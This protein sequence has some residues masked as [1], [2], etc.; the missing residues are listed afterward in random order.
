MKILIKDIQILDPYQPRNSSYKAD[1]LIEDGIIQEIASSFSPHL[2]GDVVILG[3]NKFLFPGLIDLHTHLREPGFEYKEDIASGSLAALHG[4]YT[5]ITAFPNTKP[6]SDSVERLLALKK[7]IQEKALVSVL[8]VAAITEGLEG[9]KLTPIAD[10]AKNGAVAFT[11]DGKG[12]Q[13]FS[14]ALKAMQAIQ[15]TGLPFLIHAENELLAQDGVMHSGKV[16]EKLNLKGIPPEAEESMTARDLILAKLT[17]AQIHFCHVSTAYAAKIIKLAKEE[18]V[19]V[20]AEVTPHHLCLN[21]DRI[22]DT[23]NANF[24]MNPPLRPYKDQETLIELLK[25]GDID[26]IATDH[27]PHAMHEKA[28]GFLKAPFGITG[29]ETALPLLFH[30]LVKDFQIPFLRI[31]EAL[32]LAPS[33]ILGLK[34]RPIAPKNPAD[35]VIFNTEKKSVLTQDFFYSK[36]KNFPLLNQ[37]LWGKVEYVACFNQFYD[38]TKPVFKKTSF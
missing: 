11:D 20:T 21:Q 35:F 24:K 2:K 5:T 28:L 31:I 6:V 19:K 30:T 3:K 32:T 36:S 34:K 37:E 26:A 16:S 23:H 12:V 38:F 13:D 15:K 4:G 7:L 25:N 33:K 8:P 10:L 29:L 17:Q 1:I 22:L 18:G 27:A 14:L 9:K